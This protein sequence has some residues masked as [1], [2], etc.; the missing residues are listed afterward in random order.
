M[1]RSKGLLVAIGACLCF[2]FSGGQGH[3]Q[4][5]AGGEEIGLTISWKAAP[6]VNGKTVT[7]EGTYTVSPG[8]NLIP[9]WTFHLVP[10]NG[11]KHFPVLK[12]VANGVWG[13]MS[14]TVEKGGDYYVIISGSVKNQLTAVDTFYVGA[15]YKVTIA[16]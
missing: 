16:N 12:N 9:G 13:P 5:G 7:G 10:V 14:A 8:Y 3:G 2:F 11:G 1:G 15:V 6:S 4:P